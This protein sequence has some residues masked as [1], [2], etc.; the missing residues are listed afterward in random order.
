MDRRVSLRASLRII[1]NN[2][3]KRENKITSLSRFRD[4]KFPNLHKK[5]IKDQGDRLKIFL[6]LSSILLRYFFT[7]FDDKNGDIKK[8]KLEYSGGTKDDP[9]KGDSK[10]FVAPLNLGSIRTSHSIE[11]VYKESKGNWVSAIS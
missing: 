9:F 3:E 8:E 4:E 10:K 6:K 1:R 2:I 5:K 11:S 7:W